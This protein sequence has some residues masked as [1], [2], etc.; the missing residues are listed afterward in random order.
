MNIPQL[1]FFAPATP[2]L[3]YRALNISRVHNSLQ[4]KKTVFGRSM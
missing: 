2:I 4:E 3:L 1:L